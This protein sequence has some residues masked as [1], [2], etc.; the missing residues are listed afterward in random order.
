MRIRSLGLR[1]KSFDLDPN[2]PAPADLEIDL[3]LCAYI[4]RGIRR[5]FAMLSH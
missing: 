4:P 1:M 5:L 3:K 2:V